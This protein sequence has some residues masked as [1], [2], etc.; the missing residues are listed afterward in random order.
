MT[1]E[2]ELKLLN[3][4]AK[5]RKDSIEQYRKGNREDLAKSE[6][7]ELNIIMKYLPEQMSND[8]IKNKVE[9]IAGNIGA[10]SKKDFGKLMSATM[11]ELSGKADGNIVRE[12]V[13][14]VL[15]ES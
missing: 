2:D 6:E 10:E 14:K 7:E 9:E 4:A 11:K 8:E 12:T 3:S 1:E 5:K 13:E 15:S